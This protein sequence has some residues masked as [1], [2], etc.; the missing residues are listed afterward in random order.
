MC[1]SELETSFHEILIDIALITD[2][3]FTKPNY[4]TQT[5]LRTQ[6]AILIHKSLSHYPVPV[7]PTNFTQDSSVTLSIH[8][9]SYHSYIIVSPN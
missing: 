4:S 6:P 2:T 7:T 8:S 1:A 5:T 9:S 3:D